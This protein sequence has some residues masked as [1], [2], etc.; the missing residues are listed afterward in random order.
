MSDSRKSHRFFTRFST[1]LSWQ[2]LKILG[3]PC[4]QVIINLLFL[5][6]ISWVNTFFYFFHIKQFGSQEPG[7]NSEI[8]DFAASYNVKFD[9]F[10][11]IDVNGDNAHPLWKYLK[12]KQGGTLTE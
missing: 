4:N 3:F 7:T 5:F 6:N 2:G 12:K 8:K 10:A 11:K 1:I 9:M